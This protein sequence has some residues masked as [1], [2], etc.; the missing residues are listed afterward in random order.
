MLIN[1][2]TTYPLKKVKKCLKCLKRTKKHE[3]Q[4]HNIQCTE[5]GVESNNNIIN[6]ASE[7][8]KMTQN[9]THSISF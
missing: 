5:T 4:Q 7:N 8:N 2:Y 3:Q 6:N 1:N 9:E